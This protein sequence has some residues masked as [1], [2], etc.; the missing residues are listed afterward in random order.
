MKIEPLTKA[1]VRSAAPL[2]ADF[3]VQLNSFKGVVSEPDHAAGEEELLYYLERD[4]P[5]YAAKDGD[6]IVGY[7]VCRVDEPCVWAE[8]LYVM[9]EYRRQGVA[10]A[11]FEKAEQL[12]ASFRED[13]V[14]N[15]IHPNNAAVI[16]F[17]KSRGYTVL[18]LVEV[19]KPYAGEELSKKIRV[20]DAEFD[21]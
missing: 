13:T 6:R 2:T 5:M 1:D 14:Y 17:L 19:R 16:A 11:L 20:A 21:Y 3:R 12:A 4:F 18:N 7:I 9:P 10:S 8:S 15:Y